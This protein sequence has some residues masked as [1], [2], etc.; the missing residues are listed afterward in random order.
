MELQVPEIER[1][2]G[3]ETYSTKTPGIGGTIK[4]A[5]EDFIVQEMLVDGSTASVEMVKEKPPL[6]ATATKQQF[7]ICELVKRN[8][9]TFIAIKNLAEALGVDQTRIQFAGIKDAKALTAQYITIEGVSAEDVSNV[10]VKDEKLRPLGYFHSPMSPF[11]LLG[12]DFKINIK[13]VTY[14][15]ETVQEQ[16]SETIAELAQTGG[17]PNFYGHQR[18]GTTRPITHLVG[19][20]LVQGKLEE[21]AMIFLANPS[22][23]E[24]PDSTRARTKLQS[25]Q[26]FQ[27]ALRDFPPQLRFE[28]LMIRH[29]AENAGD[30][31]GAFRR[32]PL[33]LQLLFVQGYQS[34][35]FNRFLSQRIMRGLPLNKAEAGDFVVSVER[36]GLPMIHTGRLV[37]EG[38]LSDI[39]SSIEAGKMR[40]A[41]PIVGFRQRFSQS[42]AG[43]LQHRILEDEGVTLQDFRASALPEVS[44]R[45]ELR[46]AGS[47]VNN[48]SLARTFANET[49]SEKQSI[50][51]EFALFKSSYATVLLREVMKPIDLIA[52]GF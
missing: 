20:A 38:K 49:K 11:Y 39:N 51:L 3:I 12:N 14:P 8:W 44:A 6:G 35:L 30:F 7:L 21:A 27:S 17:I 36:S 18:F 4:R 45:G 40:V 42:E 2:I 28:R 13:N 32:L 10:R 26:N 9:D 29:L 43:E 46:A 25:T 34:Y 50:E 19:K 48:F 1:Q 37:D 22:P 16:I 31:K 52:S 24:H 47:P 5:I 33:K 15:K 23:N 41:L